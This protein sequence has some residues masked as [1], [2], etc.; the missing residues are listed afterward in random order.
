M[1]TKK[2]YEK[3]NNNDTSVSTLQRFEF[4]DEMKR[5][6]GTLVQRAKLS[7]HDLSNAIKGC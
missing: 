6:E 4:D 1:N 7:T 3:G 5:A 2:K